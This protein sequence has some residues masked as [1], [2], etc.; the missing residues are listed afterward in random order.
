[1]ARM[2]HQ[3]NKA[4]CEANGDTT[5]KNWD[6]AEE[7]QRESAIKGV[8]Y[9]LDNPNA[10]EDSQHNAW[11][12]DK[13]A[14]GWVYGEVKDAEKKTHP[15]IV[16]FEQLPEFQKKKDIIFC[17]MVDALYDRTFALNFGAAQKAMLA[18]KKVARVGWDVGDNSYITRMP[19]YPD[20]IEVNEVTQKA[21]NL[22]AGT[23][24]VYTPYYQFYSRKHRNVS[25]WQPSNC[26]LNENDWFIVQ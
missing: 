17:A 18:G 11:M 10:G 8:Q 2:C 1:M 15:C 23:K 4:W 25:M 22:P 6:E 16:P 13:I 26:D 24:L 12:N 5:Q 7:W 3:A 9:R 19:G 14:D 20:G 21:H